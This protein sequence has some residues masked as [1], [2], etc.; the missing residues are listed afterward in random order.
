MLRTYNVEHIG[1]SGLKHLERPKYKQKFCDYHSFIV[2][3]RK[4]IQ[5]HAGAMRCSSK[6]ACGKQADVLSH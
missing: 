3:S 1:Y 4:G 2:P 6:H 5:L